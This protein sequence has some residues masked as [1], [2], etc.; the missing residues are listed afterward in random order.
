MIGLGVPD[1]TASLR[2]HECLQVCVS[3]IEMQAL[4]SETTSVLRHGRLDC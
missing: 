2:T 4:A 1:T 3:V